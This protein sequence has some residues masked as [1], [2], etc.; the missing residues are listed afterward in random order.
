MKRNSPS[1]PPLFSD[2]S[3][4]HKKIECALK[5]QRPNHRF[6]KIGRFVSLRLRLNPFTKGAQL[7]KHGLELNARTYYINIYIYR[8]NIKQIFFCRFLTLNKA[9]FV[10]THTEDKALLS[11]KWIGSFSPFCDKALKHFTKCM[12]K[13]I[14]AGLRRI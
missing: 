9:L 8:N 13:I 11:K 14:D 12:C 7:Q 2:I 10:F 3:E 4:L 6:A 5:R 1:P